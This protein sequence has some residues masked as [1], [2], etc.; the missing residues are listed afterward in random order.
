MGSNV[1]QSNDM[2]AE[3]LAGR[4]Q[5]IQAEAIGKC[6]SLT[7]S[8]GQRRMT[9]RSELFDLIFTEQRAVVIRTFDPHGTV[10]DQEFTSRVTV[11]LL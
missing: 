2:V 10:N 5:E 8:V 1:L 11:A 4:I 9:H 3:Y 6:K 7:L